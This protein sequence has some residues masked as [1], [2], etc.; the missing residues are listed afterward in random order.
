MKAN[1]IDFLS[2][3]DHQIAG[4]LDAFQETKLIDFVASVAFSLTMV[5]QATGFLIH[6]SVFV[7]V[8]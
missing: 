4:E 7:W 8:E 3:H 5:V 2:A 1:L 6:F